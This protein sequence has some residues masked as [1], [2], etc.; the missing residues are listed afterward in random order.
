[1]WALVSHLKDER[2]GTYT[3]NVLKH[4]L[5]AIREWWDAM[6]YDSPYIVSLFLVPM[7]FDLCL[8][9]RPKLFCKNLTWIGIQ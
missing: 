6:H 9:I 3:A 8:E 1:M 7:N 4:C 5:T 2:T